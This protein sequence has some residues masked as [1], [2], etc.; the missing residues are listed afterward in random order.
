MLRLMDAN[1]VFDPDLE[2][3][4]IGESPVGSDPI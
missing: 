1:Q 3:K 4:L 2:L